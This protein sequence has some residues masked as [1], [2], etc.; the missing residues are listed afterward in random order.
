M[1][2]RL[3]MGTHATVLGLLGIPLDSAEVAQLKNI[4]TQTDATI[5]DDGQAFALKALL[6]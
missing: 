2:H 3:L 5:F 1:A 4:L 6:K